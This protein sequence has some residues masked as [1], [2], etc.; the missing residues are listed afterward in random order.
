VASRPVTFFCSIDEG[1]P[2]PC[3]SPFVPATPLEDGEHTITVIGTD[4]AG[5]S[6]SSEPEAF[7]IDTTPPSTSIRKHPK[8]VV[9]TTKRKVRLRFRF[10]ADEPGAT[11]VCRIDGAAFRECPA[12]LV[13][14]FKLGKH[15]LQV[16]ARDPLG[17]VDSTPAAF[18]FRVERR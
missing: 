15:K 13:R 6:G 8:K 18:S 12:K 4:L 7:A 9:R 1:V 11:F 10:A 17:N 5:R 14:A 16:K 3:S 2:I